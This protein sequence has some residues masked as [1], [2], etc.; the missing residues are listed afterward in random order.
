MYLSWSL[1]QSLNNNLPQL[2]REFKGTRYWLIYFIFNLQPLIMEPYLSKVLT[3]IVIITLLSQKLTNIKSK[4]DRMRLQEPIPRPHSSFMIPSFSFSLLQSPKSILYSFI[5][6][7]YTQLTYPS[8]H[9]QIIS[10]DGVE[11]G[12]LLVPTHSSGIL[13]FHCN[14]NRSIIRCIRIITLFPQ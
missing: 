1:H 10:N 7:T 5:F 9:V 4:I 6:V 13:L 12:G 11:E 8:V 2:I 14:H 3:G